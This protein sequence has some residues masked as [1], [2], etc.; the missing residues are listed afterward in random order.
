MI[1]TSSFG[2]LVIDGK[3]Y[4]SDLIIFPEGHVKDRWRRKQGHRLFIED[5]KELI[6][7]SPELIICG[8]GVSGR[9]KPDQE[10]NK[11]LKDLEIDF[12]PAPN[13]EAIRLYNEISPKKRSG[14]CFHLTC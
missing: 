8:T 3:E 1:N 10:V 14:A 7:S 11:Y 2:F 12:I 4:N 5:I 9:M 13:K 6:E